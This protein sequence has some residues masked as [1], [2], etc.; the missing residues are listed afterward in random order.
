MW[1]AGAGRGGGERGEGCVW[2]GEGGGE[3]LVATLWAQGHKKSGQGHYKVTKLAG[4]VIARSRDLV[5]TL[6]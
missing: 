2:R 1:G 3:D 6:S 5:V 4:K